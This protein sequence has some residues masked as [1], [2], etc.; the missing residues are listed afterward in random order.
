MVKLRSEQYQIK[1]ARWMTENSSNNLTFLINYF[2]LQRRLAPSIL[3]ENN[4]ICLNLRGIVQKLRDFYKN[5][6]RNWNYFLAQ[7]LDLFLHIY[8]Q[9]R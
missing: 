2:F 3:L 7:D 8:C 9:Y 1:D 5:I 6:K 4:H